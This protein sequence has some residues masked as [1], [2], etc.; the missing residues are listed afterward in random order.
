MFGYPAHGATTNPR[1]ADRAKR[2][3]FDGG[4]T[5]DRGGSTADRRRIEADRR[6]LEADRGGST[7]ARRRIEADRRRIEAVR[8]WFDGGSSLGLAV[9]VQYIVWSVK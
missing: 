8:Q 7:A 4:S 6:R 1:T 9:S 3:R 5:A 2:Y